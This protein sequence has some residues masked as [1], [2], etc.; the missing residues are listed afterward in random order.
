MTY[1]DGHIEIGTLVSNLVSHFLKVVRAW[2]RE[3]SPN[4][5]QTSKN[6]AVEGLGGV[7]GGS[8]R[9]LGVSWEDLGVAWRRF[10]RS[11]RYVGA[12]WGDLGAILGG[13]RC[14]LEGF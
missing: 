3:A 14:V 9:V 12:S 2:N 5:S 8:W 4:P 6:R 7:L 10:G 13:S 1:G 11:W